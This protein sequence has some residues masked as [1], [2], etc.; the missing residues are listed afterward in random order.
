MSMPD[1]T[2]R[3]ER[4]RNRSIKNAFCAMASFIFA[5]EHGYYAKRGFND[6]HS[7]HPHEHIGKRADAH[8]V[9][10]ACPSER[11]QDALVADRA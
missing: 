1:T 10:R 7:R 2:Y 8:V 3:A 6:I 11:R 5:A 9:K 4:F